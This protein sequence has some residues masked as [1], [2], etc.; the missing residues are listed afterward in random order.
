MRVCF[1]VHGLPPTERGG[2][3]QCTVALA[4]ELARR[5]HAVEVFAPTRRESL[6]DRALRR[7]RRGAWHVTW[8][9][10]L[11]APSD[12]A[13]ELDPP[14]VADAFARFLDAERP[15]V[16]HVQHLLR[17]GL[18]ILDAAADF[19][20]PLVSTAHDWYALT[21]SFALVRPDLTR[22]ASVPTPEEEARAD[23][24]R[25]ILNRV[26]ALGAY[27]L[28]VPPDWLPEPERARFEATL[29]G[30][31]E[32]AGFHENEWSEA[33][34]RRE[35]MAAR[36]REAFSKVDAFVS[37]SAFLAGWLE[38]GFGDAKGDAEGGRAPSV[39]H[40]PNGIDSARL[41]GV[42]PV[43]PSTGRVRLGFVG[44]LTKHK[45]VHLLLEA[46]ALLG[47]A[48]RARLPLVIHGDSTDRV[49]TERIAARAQALGATF[50]GAFDGEDLPRVLAGID[51]LVVPSIWYENFPTVLREAYAAGRI[52]VAS[53]L[54]ALPE[55]VRDGVDGLL[56]R[57][58]DAQDLARVLRRLVDEDGL[59]A[60][61][62]AGVPRVVGIDEQVDG[63]EALYAER[64]AAR[65]A[66]RDPGGGLAHLATLGAR[67]RELEA[68]P[69]RE[70]LERAVAG[71]GR[72]SAVLGVEADPSA[73]IARGVGEASRTLEELRDRRTESGYLA[74]LIDERERRARWLDERLEGADA[75]RE[76]LRTDRESLAQ[77]VE[78]HERS[79]RELEKERDWLRQVQSD[80]E[81]ERDWLR[82]QTATLGEERDWLARKQE[83]LAKERERLTNTLHETRSAAE[84]ERAW[85]DAM[86]SE[87]ERERDWL[88]SEIRSREEERKWL[89]SLISE[90][91]EALT[92]VWQLVEGRDSD[93]SKLQG[94]IE[95]CERVANELLGVFGPSVEA[96]VEAEVEAAAPEGGGKLERM[97]G[98][99]Y[100]H[101]HALLAQLEQLKEA[102]DA[103][104]RELAWRR[105][106]MDGARLALARRTVSWLRYFTGI[107]K[108][109]AAWEPRDGAT[110]GGA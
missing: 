36:R 42:P 89:A 77:A 50:A 97:L 59:V 25:S 24:A 109:V 64:L 60:S 100:D 90:K 62:L 13:E 52:A 104:Q 102:Q 2:V 28:G 105:D 22:Y 66:P 20:A 39:V 30:D 96:E 103:S 79:T 99:L 9:N 108:R 65:E 101:G 1:V 18:G 43:D 19:G 5:G 106:E 56:F 67:Y 16:V 85:R 38:R 75:E 88:R 44:S 80:F 35:A 47:D 71:V 76:W 51:A 93:L 107:G 6:P 95:A 81:R 21:D 27:H 3:E 53:D 32:A 45:G 61:L 54:G 98:G 92:Y 49:Y 57:P 72:L 86:T 91:E 37:P 41:A 40:Q 10:L 15:E 83:E 68:L 26:E 46:Y 8:V 34:A 48:E 69:T 12:P 14:G 31:R 78:F 63:I 70:L 84:K 29:A 82:A 87:M 110:G 94:E 11:T 17:L 55:S 7:E 58:D 23:L 33:L 74:Q 4:D 73:L